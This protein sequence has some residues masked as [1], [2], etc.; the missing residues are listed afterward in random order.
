MPMYTD[1]KLVRSFPCMVLFLLPSAVAEEE[2][3]EKKRGRKDRP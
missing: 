3:A 2:E 1:T